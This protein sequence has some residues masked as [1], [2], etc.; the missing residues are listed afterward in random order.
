MTL[1][2]AEAR[3]GSKISKNSADQFTTQQTESGKR[4]MMPP[5]FQKEQLETPFTEKTRV[6]SDAVDVVDVV[7][8]PWNGGWGH[9]LDPPC[10]WAAYKMSESRVLSSDLPTKIQTNI[11]PPVEAI[12]SIHQSFFIRGG[13]TC[14]TLCDIFDQ[15]LRPS[16]R[17][18]GDTV[19]IVEESPWKML[20]QELKRRRSSLALSR[21]LG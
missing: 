3:P 18:R 4:E 11:N 9:K 19:R 1:S 2:A 14:D 10:L 12:H 21:A 20:S 13:M 5:I 6:S 7:A 8:R 17:R 16:I 15:A